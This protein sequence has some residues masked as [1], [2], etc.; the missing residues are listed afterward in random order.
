M[1]TSDLAPISTITSNDLLQIVDVDD[2]LMAASGTNKQITAVDAANALVA[3]ANSTTIT[4]R[5]DTNSLSGAKIVD[6]TI[7][8]DKLAN[9]TI[10][11]AK[12]A[13][14]A[15]IA[16][17]KISP[18]FTTTA[19]VTAT[20]ATTPTLT[21]TQNGTGPALAIGDS[22]IDKTGKLSIGVA[23]IVTG[24]AAQIS[25][26]VTE[27]NGLDLA[28]GQLFIT[29][30]DNTTT[31][32]LM[33]GYRFQSGV[34]EYG[35]IQARSTSGVT[36]SA[37][38]L[39]LQ[40]GGGAVGIGKVP[41]AGRALDVVGDVYATKFYGDFQGNLSG[42]FTGT[43]V[44]GVS[45][46]ST[47]V[48]PGSI[49]NAMVSTTA[50]IVGTK[51][52]P[53]F[54]TQNISTTGA[55]GIGAVAPTNGD[56]LTITNSGGISLNISNTGDDSS[57]RITHTGGGD[58]FRI[59]RVA[60]DPHPIIVRPN[61]TIVIGNTTQRQF[62]VG[63]QCVQI[64]GET[65]ETS[66]VQMWR[67][68]GTGVEGDANFAFVKSRGTLAAPTQ[69]VNGDALG[70]L[71][72][73]G[74][75]ATNGAEAAASIRAHADDTVA[76]NKVPGRLTFQTANSTGVSQERLR[77]NSAGNIGI[78][79]TSPTEKLHV[80]GNIKIGS[81]VFEQPAGTAPLFGA[82]AWA[83]FNGQDVTGV[84]NR[85]S[86][87][88]ALI[89]LDLN[90]HGLLQGQSVYLEFSGSSSPDT[91][92]D[93]ETVVNSNRVIVKV[94]GSTANG[95][96]SNVTVTRHGHDISGPATRAAGSQLVTVDIVKH[97]LRNGDRVY[98]NWTTVLTDGVYEVTRVDDN[99]FTIL[100][101]AT[102]P[103]VSTTA[104]L[105]RPEFKGGGNISNISRAGATG[106]YYIN[107]ETPLPNKNYAVIGS[108]QQDETQT[109]GSGNGTINGYAVSERTAYV[110]TVSSGSNLEDWQHVSTVIFG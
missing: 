2:T 27:T 10:T 73:Y 62:P 32:G 76:S 46:T 66:S 11:D 64:H 61:K 98:I 18:I 100:S 95:Q 5:I 71:T 81:A 28:Q 39:V 92:Y 84:A 83:N 50:A 15:A 9:T 65:Y 52:A 43:V 108:G 74:Y 36:A 101:G 94:P 16:G 6:T 26:Q 30:S 75:D 48:T 19:S 77:I 45:G 37:T 59:N 49:T 79:T 72:F 20:H 86:G 104:I 40:G 87:I 31:S 24:P 47:G 7:S 23:S 56:K 38:A 96:I 34:G 105:K 41:A 70:A 99:T 88:V 82:R 4:N 63:P 44:G 60:A 109:N 1:R 102:T 8:N 54:G 89:T 85:T 35:R 90:N 12:I 51:I 21:L 57:L 13:T 25:G 91:F 93:V 42:T 53:N 3:L 68:T 58:I 78:G 67:A 55:V 110:N 107:F 69:V 106:E 97:R 80:N 22:R 14:G 103:A 33:I 17:S 29:D